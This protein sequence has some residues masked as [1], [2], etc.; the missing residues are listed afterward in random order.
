MAVLP[1]RV[2]FGAAYHHEYQPCDR[3]KTDLDLM[4]EVNFTVI[5]VGESV[6]EPENGPQLRP[7]PAAGPSARVGD[8][9]CRRPSPPPP[10]PP[11]TA[12]V[13]ASSTTGAGSRSEWRPRWH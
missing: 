11:R 3:L 10:D 12:V 9:T 5:R 8:T 6:W 4:A 13:F 1:A 7:G 2:P